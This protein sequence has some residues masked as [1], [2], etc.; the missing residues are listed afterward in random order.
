MKVV[1]EYCGSYVEADENM[2]CPLCL[3]ELGSAVQAQEARAEQKE[4]E[5]RQQEA[6]EKAQEAK[7]EHVSEIIKG[8]T[9]VATA[10][11]GAH[12]AASTAEKTTMPGTAGSRPVP[13]FDGRPPEPPEGRGRHAHRGAPDSWDG[14]PG[15]G[16]SDGRDEHPRMGGFGSHNHAPHPG[17]PGGPGR[18]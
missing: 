1:C 11:I 16:A 10:L 12:A 8:I 3:G 14:R 13:P 4:E 5:E 18:H 17:G 7:D 2:R 9:G 15:L 6:E